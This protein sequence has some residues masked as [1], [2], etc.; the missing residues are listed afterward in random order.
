MNEKGMK[1]QQERRV[2]SVVC[3]KGRSE[4]SPAAGKKA[5]NRSK[6]SRQTEAQHFGTSKWRCVVESVSGRVHYFCHK[7]QAR[8]PTKQQTIKKETRKRENKENAVT[9]EK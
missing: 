1:T 7:G 2:T 3:E 8:T 5:V 6:R 4:R 9:H